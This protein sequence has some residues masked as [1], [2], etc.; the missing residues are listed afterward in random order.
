MGDNLDRDLEELE[1]GAAAPPAPEPAPAKPARRRRRPKAKGLELDV[2]LGDVGVAT[3]TLNERRY[4]PQPGAT[5]LNA[6]AKAEADRG[7]LEGDLVIV[8][9][10]PGAGPELAAALREVLA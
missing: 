4:H 7:G 10:D 8:A 9:V 2:D 3:I 5:V 1:Q 6:G